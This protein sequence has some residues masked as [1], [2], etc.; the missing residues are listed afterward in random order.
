MDSLL[1]VLHG[2]IAKI[3][4]KNKTIKTLGT[5]GNHID[6]KFKGMIIFKAVQKSNLRQLHVDHCAFN[7]GGAKALTEMLTFNSNIVSVNLWGNLITLE[8]AHLLVSLITIYRKL[9]FDEEYQED[10]TVKGF[11]QNAL[12]PMCNDVPYS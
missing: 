9:K 8:G 6:N 5:H 4:E 7:F 3:L 10:P 12:T 11:M 2:P 1:R